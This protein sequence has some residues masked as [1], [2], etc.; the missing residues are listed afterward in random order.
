MNE[1]ESDFLRIDLDRLEVEWVN[2]PILVY[3]YNKKAADARLAMDESKQQLDVEYAEIDRNIREDPKLYGLEEKTTEAGIKACI[4]ESKAY[5]VAQKEMFKAKHK[6]DILNAI[7]IAL[8]HKKRAL[9]NLVTLHGQA[10]FS[11]PRAKGAGNRELMETET[12]RH[13]RSLGRKRLEEEKE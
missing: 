6:V 11:E 3:E 2:Q 13:V 5:K 7:C 12:K 8:E 9:E 1:L 10:Y 4:I